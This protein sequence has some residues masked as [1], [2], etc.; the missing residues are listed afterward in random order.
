MPR[1]PPLLCFP[2]SPPH[3]RCFNY[4]CFLFTLELFEFE[5]SFFRACLE[6]AKRFRKTPLKNVFFFFHFVKRGESAPVSYTST[7]LINQCLTVTFLNFSQT[8]DSFVLYVFDL[9]PFLSA[10]IRNQVTIP[11]PYPFYFILFYFILFPP[12]PTRF[13]FFFSSFSPHAHANETTLRS[14]I[15]IN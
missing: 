4:Y 15:R 7:L 10:F 2:P 5:S 1:L 6:E 3:S 11:L 12:T 14:S 8:S 13:S 9:F